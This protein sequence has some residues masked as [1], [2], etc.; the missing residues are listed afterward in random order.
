MP[1]MRFHH[2]GIPTDRSLPEEDYVAEFKL[3]ASGYADSPYGVEWMRFD[4]DCPLPDL[5]K[6]VAHVAFAVDDLQAAIAGQEVLIAPNS[7]VDGV[8]VAFIVHHGAPIEFLQ[9][10]GPEAEVW[11]DHAPFRIP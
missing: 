7:P 8:T 1:E 2:V 3:Y 4:P 10:D 5:I 11:P 6:R 9:F